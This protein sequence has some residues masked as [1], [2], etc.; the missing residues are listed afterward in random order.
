MGGVRTDI[1]SYPVVIIMIG[2][3]FN[4]VIIHSNE[5]LIKLVR[6]SRNVIAMIQLN[7]LLK[8]TDIM[9]ILAVTLCSTWFINTRV[10]DRYYYVSNEDKKA[11]YYL[12]DNL[13]DNSGLIIYPHAKKTFMDIAIM[14]VLGIIS[15]LTLNDQIRSIF[16]Q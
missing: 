3:G 13:P 16:Q 12:N 10:N 11:V 14:L 8:C 7:N 2:L 1:F 4:M 9:L 15:I 5:C 6:R